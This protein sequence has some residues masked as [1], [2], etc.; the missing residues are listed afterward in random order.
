MPLASG[1]SRKTVSKNIREMMDAG[2]PQDQAV[3]ASLRQARQSK[4][5][6]RTSPRGGGN[7]DSSTRFRGRK[8]HRKH[9]RKGR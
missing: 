7:M 8:G 4:R 2:H 5:H 3:A 6:K 1:S 9:G